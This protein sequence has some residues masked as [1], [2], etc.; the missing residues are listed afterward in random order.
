L[1]QQTREHL[2]IQMVAWKLHKIGKEKGWIDKEYYKDSIK[3]SYK[4]A[5]GN[6]VKT[7]FLLVKEY[8]LSKWKV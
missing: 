6:Q 8:D 3:V 4:D 1:E 5:S 7:D 2:N